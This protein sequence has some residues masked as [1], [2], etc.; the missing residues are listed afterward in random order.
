VDRTGKSGEKELWVWEIQ[1]VAVDLK[2]DFLLIVQAWIVVD[3][4]VAV[5]FDVDIVV[6]VDMDFVVDFVE[7]T[8][9]SETEVEGFVN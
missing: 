5:D 3:I 7:Q 4:V 6:A 2:G 1:T 8:N 9:L